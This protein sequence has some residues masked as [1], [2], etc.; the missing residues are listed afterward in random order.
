MRNASGKKG[1]N[2]RQSKTKKRPTGTQAAKFFGSTYDIFSIKRV[3]RKFYI[4][5]TTEEKCTKK[6]AARATLLF[7]VFWLSRPT[8]IFCHSRCCNRLA[9]QDFIFFS[10]L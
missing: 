6:C 4:A 3:K 2:E 1:E 5:T 7:L 8:D 9:S 10:K